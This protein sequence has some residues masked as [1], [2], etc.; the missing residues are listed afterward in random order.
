MKLKKKSYNSKK[1][2]TKIINYQKIIN[3]KIKKISIK[4]KM[5]REVIGAMKTI[6]AQGMNMK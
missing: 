5:R 6:A 1:K 2:T 4:Q 3:P